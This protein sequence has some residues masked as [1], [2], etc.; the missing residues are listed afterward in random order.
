MLREAK[1]RQ[2]VGEPQ[3]RW[4]RDEDFDLYVWA[5]RDGRIAGFQ[6]CYDKRTSEHAFTW[7]DDRGMAHHRVDDPERGYAAAQTPLLVPGD[8]F[9]ADRVRINFQAASAAIDPSVRAKV[10]EI[11]DLAV[12]R[13]DAGGISTPRP[14]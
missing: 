5:H 10:I 2:I 6:L 7:L 11:L 9:S 3:R 4:F 13:T 1:A 12:N 8:R 14:D